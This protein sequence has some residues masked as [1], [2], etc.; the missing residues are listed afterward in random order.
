[1][2]MQFSKHW[3]MNLLLLPGSLILNSSVWWCGF[4]N[5]AVGAIL[6]NGW[7]DDTVSS[8]SVQNNHVCAFCMLV[9]GISIWHCLIDLARNGSSGCANEILGCANCHFWWKSPWKWKN[10]G[11]FRVCNWLNCPCKT[12]VHGWLAKTVHCLGLCALSNAYQ[13][14]VQ[15]HC[16]YK[17]RGM[18]ILCMCPANERWRYS[19]TPSLIGWAYTQNDPCPYR[20]TQPMSIERLHR[21]INS[22]MLKLLTVISANIMN[23][24][25]HA[26]NFPLLWM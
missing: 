24:P 7:L 13:A 1:M 6:A 18:N 19:V 4:A 26:W 14:Q 10:L 20:P 3:C 17:L 25:S 8:I 15:A 21:D 9:Y 12:R 22:L 23:C 16:S 2:P 5:I 11:D